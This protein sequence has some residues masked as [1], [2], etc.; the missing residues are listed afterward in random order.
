MKEEGKKEIPVKKE[1]RKKYRYK[2]RKKYNGKKER[3]KSNGKK[4]GKKLLSLSVS[5]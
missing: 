5:V 4:E 3:K 2:E 1:K